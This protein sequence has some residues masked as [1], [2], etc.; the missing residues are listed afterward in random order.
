MALEKQDFSLWQ[1][2]TRTL[3][4]TIT[5]TDVPTANAIKWA[6]ATGQGRIVLTKSL[7]ATDITRTGQVVSV[8][9]F[10]SDTETLQPGEYNHELRITDED[11]QEDVVAVGSAQLYLSITK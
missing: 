4:Y 8:L 7:A 1:G 5:G 6:L 3:I 10:P 9:L 11:D 2:A